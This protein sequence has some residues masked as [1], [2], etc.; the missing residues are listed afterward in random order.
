MISWMFLTR[1]Q[2]HRESKALQATLE[3]ALLIGGGELWK[4]SRKTVSSVRWTH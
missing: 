3:Y 4:P 2:G 1:G